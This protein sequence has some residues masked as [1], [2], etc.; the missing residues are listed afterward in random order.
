MY[1]KKV[2]TLFYLLTLN[3]EIMTIPSFRSICLLIVVNIC[4]IIFFYVMLSNNYGFLTN[5]RND[6]FLISDGLK[7]V[8]LVT[9]FILTV[10]ILNVLIFKFLLRIKNQPI[11]SSIKVSVGVVIVGIL[12]TIGIGLFHNIN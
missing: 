8:K 7:I 4:T 1:R 6:I 12:L 5:E 11:Y 10:F 2:H 9:V 3:Y